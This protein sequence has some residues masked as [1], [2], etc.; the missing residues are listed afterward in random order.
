MNNLNY[1]NSED[2]LTTNTRKVLSD[3]LRKLLE[4]D[5][6]RVKESCE[7]LEKPIWKLFLDDERY[8]VDD[9]MIIARSF[10]EAKSLVL[11]K[12]CPIYISFDHDLG[13]DIFWKV[14][15]SWFDFTK[16]L[17]EEDIKNDIIPT[18]FSFY[19]H[20]M[21]PIGKKNIEDYINWYLSFKKRNNDSKNSNTL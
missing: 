1:N 6:V 19:V 12:G 2:I 21:N 15:K 8:P 5:R 9:E 20:S 13:L 16:W 4:Q 7:V 17:V 14:A 18:N 10:E 3:S 11:V